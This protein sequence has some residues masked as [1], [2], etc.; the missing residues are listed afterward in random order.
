M[1]LAIIIVTDQLLTCVLGYIG[2]LSHNEHPP[3]VWHI[4]LETL[5]I[6]IYI[7]TCVSVYI[8]VY[9]YVYIYIYSY[10]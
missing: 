6:Y 2:I 9:M 7:Y 8:Y 1:C 10:S 5:C 3:E 4:L